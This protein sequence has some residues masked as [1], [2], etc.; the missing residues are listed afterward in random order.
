MRN[1]LAI[2]LI[3]CLLVGL[4]AAV[5]TARADVEPP[6]WRQ[7]K[8]ERVWQEKIR[9]AVFPD[10]TINTSRAAGIL[11]IK[12][13]YRAED[14]TVVPISIHTMLPQTAQRYIRKIHVYVDRNPVPLVGVFEFTPRSGRADLAMRIRVNDQSYVRAIAE[15][16]DGE[17]YMVKSF[18]RAT[19]ACS[20]PPPP[21]IEDSFAHMGRMKIRTVGKS[22]LHEPNLV[23]LKIQHPNITGMQPLRIGSRVMPPPHYI[24]EIKVDYNG[25]PVLKARLTFSISMDPSFRFFVLPEKAG[26][27]HI[28]AIDTKNNTWSDDYRIST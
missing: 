10:Q 8:S 17:L 9:P 15:M 28:T 20:A 26:T 25:Q 11:S 24:R 1:I 5:T 2:V 22:G 4:L 7:Q 3:N 6:D 23:Q 18:V 16:N 21:S 19:G 27:L 12:A 13:P 14:A